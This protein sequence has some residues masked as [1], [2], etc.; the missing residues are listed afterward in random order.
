MCELLRNTNDLEAC[1]IN[2]IDKVRSLD[3]QRCHGRDVGGKESTSSQGR[4][5]ELSTLAHVFMSPNSKLTRA[6]ANC[7]VDGCMISSPKAELEEIAN[8]RL[9]SRQ[10]TR[11]TSATAQRS[12]RRLEE[13]HGDGKEQWK[14]RTL[15]PRGVQH[16]NLWTAQGARSETKEACKRILDN[17]WCINY[18]PI[19]GVPGRLIALAPA[20]PCCKSPDAKLVEE[21]MIL[22]SVPFSFNMS[23]L[24]LP[25]AAVQQQDSAQCTADCVNDSFSSAH[26]L[27][28][29]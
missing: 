4:S 16:V 22:V 25:R 5:Q 7:G 15:S 17:S 20:D 13:E 21:S 6:M 23:R 12:K 8:E 2:A 11:R 9:I 1:T 19:A 3:D 27:S 28:D 26:T 18:R 14:E 10:M 29:V 24:R